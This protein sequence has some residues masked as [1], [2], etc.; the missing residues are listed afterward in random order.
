[1]MTDAAELDEE[2]FEFR[3]SEM[4]TPPTASRGRVELGKH[5]VQVKVSLEA[6]VAQT[7]EHSD[8]HQSSGKMQ[9]IQRAE[10]RTEKA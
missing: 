2:E 9:I 7:L 1:M 4:Q 6:H 5:E 8:S 3:V 10:Q